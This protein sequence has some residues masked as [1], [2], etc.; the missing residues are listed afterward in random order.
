MSAQ[1]ESSIL[2]VGLSGT[3]KTN[4][5]VGLDVIL[6]EQQDRNGLVHSDFAR[7][8][9]YLQPLREQWLKG[10]EL[11]HTSRLIPPPPHQLLVKHPASGTCA[12]FHI[13]DVAG[14]T[15]DSHFVTR[16]VP[17]ELGNRIQRAA[18][19]ILF[20]H[21]DDE[22]D[23][24]LHDHPAF[25]DASLVDGAE[26]AASPASAPADWRLEDASKQVKLVDLMQFVAEMRLRRTPFRVAF[27]ISAWD[28]VEDAPA[29]LMPKDPVRFLATRWPL[30]YQFLETNG[31][32]F[33][34]RVFGVSARGG[35]NTPEEIARLTSFEH[36]RDRII[37]VDDANRSNDLTRPVRWLLGLL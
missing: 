22:A 35:G 29:H 18:G 25:L 27:V 12:T 11:D 37:V 33:S 30:L 1:P 13:P 6:D 10:E 19:I 34:F 28:R 32:I 36:P 14:E 20:V 17:K 7:D 24:A 2:L 9:A 15:F 31:E 3:G 23:H 16:S 8:R 26:A 5:L 21:C 4:F